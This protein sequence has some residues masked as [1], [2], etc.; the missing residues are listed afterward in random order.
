[1]VQ[2]IGDSPRVDLPADLA[3]SNEPFD[4]GCHQ[5]CISV[6]IVNQALHADPV[7]GSQQHFLATVPEN[8]RERATKLYGE[9]AAESIVERSQQGRRGG[10]S[11]FAGQCSKLLL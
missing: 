5:Q 3:R 9:V 6:L 7:D 10:A 4:T 1:E 11:W 2:H 8:Q